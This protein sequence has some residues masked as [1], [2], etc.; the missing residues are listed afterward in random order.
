MFTMFS[1]HTKMT[2]E[3]RG[4]DEVFGRKLTIKLTGLS[5]KVSLEAMM[6]YQYPYNRETDNE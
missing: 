2:P 3:K 6:G 4:Q 5:C 1:A